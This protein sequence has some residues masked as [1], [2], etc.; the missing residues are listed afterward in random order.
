MLTPD[1]VTWPFGGTFLPMNLPLDRMFGFFV[2]AYLAEGCLTDHQVHIANVDEDYRNACKAW[3]DQY[4]IKS[5][6]TNESGRQKN[7]GTS[8]SIMFHSTLLVHLLQ[9]TCGKTSYKKRVP[10]FAFAAPTVF[11]EGLI[12][13][14][15]SGDGFIATKSIYITASSR[16]KTLRDGISLLLARFGITCTLSERKTQNHVHWTTLDDG[17]RVQEKYGDYVPIYELKLNACN[18][19]KFAAHIRLILDYKQQRLDELQNSMSKSVKTKS[20]MKEVVLDPIAKL[21]DVE[22]SHEFVYDLTVAQTRNMT[23]T[24]GFVLSDTFHFAGCAAKNVTLGIPRLK[25]LLD[26]S[27]NPKTPSTTIRFKKPFSQNLEFVTYFANTLS[28]T[29]LGD[30]VTKCEILYD[31]D[32]RTATLRKTS[33]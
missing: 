2:G 11:V 17:R 28:L 23:A 14:Y 26:V 19:Y 10:S 27:K 21:E 3:A 31:G 30:V 29:R 4:D 13:G 9:R 33:G 16:S 20:V 22:S 24:D 5:H 15:M 7:N 32:T 8:I 12:D 25:E 1:M 6:V 18:T